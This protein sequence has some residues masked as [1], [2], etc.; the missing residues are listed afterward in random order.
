MKKIIII[1]VIVLAAVVLLASAFLAVV[2]IRQ[3]AIKSHDADS[4]YSLLSS[5]TI[6]SITANGRVRQINGAE[7][8]IENAGHKIMFSVLENAPIYMLGAVSG[9]MQK[10]LSFGE[11]KEG[12]QLNVSLK[13]DEKGNS[14]AQSV[15]I[16]DRQ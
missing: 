11:I 5:R 4:L 7:L 6:S 12:D 16:L 1:S 2:K 10:K 3:M 8:T 14:Q 15:I 9:G 13:I